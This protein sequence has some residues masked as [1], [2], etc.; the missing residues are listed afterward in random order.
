MLAAAQPSPNFSYAYDSAGEITQWQQIQNGNNQNATY[1]YDLAGQLTSVQGG[2][3]NL[4]P[5]YAN[6]NYYAYDLA[7]NRTAVQKSAKQSAKIGGTVTTELPPWPVPTG[8]FFDPLLI[9][10]QPLPLLSPFFPPSEPQYGLP[11]PVYIPP[12]P[13]YTGPP[14]L[15]PIILPN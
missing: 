1:G 8:P 6:Q 2:L 3:T 10:G 4:P 11:A 5:S 12:L 14:G 7:S 13:P 9:P 15:A